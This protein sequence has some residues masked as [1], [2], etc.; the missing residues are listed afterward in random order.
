MNGWID[1]RDE[2]LEATDARNNIDELEEDDILA[3]KVLFR[4]F[5]KKLQDVFPLQNFGGS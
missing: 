2:W 3:E 5:Y 1:F 4:K